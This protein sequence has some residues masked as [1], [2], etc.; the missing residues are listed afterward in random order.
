MTEG[1]SK[2]EICKIIK[3]HLLTKSICPA[4]ENTSVTLCTVLTKAVKSP[5]L[6]EC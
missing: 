6:N 1:D 2:N 4:W 5:H 3:S